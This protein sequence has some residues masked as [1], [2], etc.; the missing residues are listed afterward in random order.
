[1]ISVCDQSVAGD[2]PGAWWHRPG[3]R[4]GPARTHRLRRRR[5]VAVRL[6]DGLRDAAHERCPVVLEREPDGANQDE[7]ARSKWVWRGEL[8]RRL[9]SV[10]N[11]LLD[12]LAEFGIRHIDMPATPEAVWRPIQECAAGNYNRIRSNC[13]IF[14][15]SRNQTRAPLFRV[16]A[17]GRAPAWICSPAWQ[18]LPVAGLPPASLPV[19][20]VSRRRLFLPPPEVP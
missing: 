16:R 9:P 5:I 15:N 3:D 14:K 4:A 7:P 13:M 6:L 10:R 12:A 19:P 18:S 8:C 1:M 2:G 17:G 11:A 20:A